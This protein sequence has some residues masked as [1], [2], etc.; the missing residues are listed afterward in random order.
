[1]CSSDNSLTGDLCLKKTKQVVSFEKVLYFKIGIFSYMKLC[2][3]RYCL[4]FKVYTDSF[5]VVS[6][7]ALVTLR[8]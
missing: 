2:F 5:W 7:G 1:M 6:K 3:Q 8:H 4:N